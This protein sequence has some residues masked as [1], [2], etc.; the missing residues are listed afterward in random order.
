MCR[1]MEGEEMVG[2]GRREE[3]KREENGLMNLLFLA[4]AQSAEV[5]RRCETHGLSVPVQE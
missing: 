5:L 2:R 1:G 3:E 4:L